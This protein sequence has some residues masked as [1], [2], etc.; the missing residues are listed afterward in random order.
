MAAPTQPWEY[1]L[2][3]DGYIV[4]D[5]TSYVNPV[6]TADHNWLHLEARYNYENLRT[7]SL[8]VGYNFSVGKTLSL[9]VTPMIGGIFGR[10]N[11]IAPGCEAVLTYKK[12]EDRFCCNDINGCGSVAAL[13][14]EERE[15]GEARFCEPYRV[16]SES[17]LFWWLSL[18]KAAEHCPQFLHS[19]FNRVEFLVDCTQL[20]VNRVLES[21]FRSVCR[22]RFHNPA[23]YRLWVSRNKRGGSAVNVTAISRQRI[24]SLLVQ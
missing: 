7:G 10:T 20:G 16:Q 15:K 4:P 23:L 2:T 17:F 1:N 21:L 8:W 18:E 14:F 11:G 13:K 9:S 5:D 19:G 12:I 3:I 22:I 24:N 6:L